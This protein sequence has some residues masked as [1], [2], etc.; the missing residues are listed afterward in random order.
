LRYRTA[1]SSKISRRNWEERNEQNLSYEQVFESTRH[2]VDGAAGFVAAATVGLE[3]LGR[4]KL[5]EAHTRWVPETLN[6]IPL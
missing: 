6:S 4:F 2:K 3:N 1:V 5:M